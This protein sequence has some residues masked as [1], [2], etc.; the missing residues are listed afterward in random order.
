MGRLKYT[1]PIAKEAHFV[2]PH[3]LKILWAHSAISTAS[4]EKEKAISIALTKKNSR[5]L[6]SS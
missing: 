6:T 4:S 5:R 1:R 3:F 2:L